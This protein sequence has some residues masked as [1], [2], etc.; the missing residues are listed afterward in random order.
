MLKMKKTIFF[1]F[2]FAQM[3]IVASPYKKK[4]TIFSSPKSNLGFYEWVDGS[5]N[6]K[7]GEGQTCLYFG[8]GSLGS[9]PMA[10]YRSRYYDKNGESDYK[11]YMYICIYVL[12]FSSIV[13]VIIMKRKKKRKT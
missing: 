10:K 2:I 5:K 3:S 11:P 13:T 12:L 6:P 4:I 8:I 1:A 9:I 7:T